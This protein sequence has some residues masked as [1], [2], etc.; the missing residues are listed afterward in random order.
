M[1]QILPEASVPEIVT[2]LG[3]FL[4][5]NIGVI[6]SVISLSVAI[7]LIIRMFTQ[8][9]SRITNDS[10]AQEKGFKNYDDYRRNV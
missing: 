9:T 6:I 3:E 7:T 1:A 4:F 5:D 2:S 8:V 10:L